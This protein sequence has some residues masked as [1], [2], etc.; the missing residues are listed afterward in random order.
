MKRLL[1][2]SLALVFCG[3]AAADHHKKG[4]HDGPPS[5]AVCVLLPTVGSQVR[6]TIMFEEKDGKVHVTG[7]VSGLTPNGKH[8]FHIHEFGDL[9]D[10][11]EGKSTGGHFS[12]GGHQHGKPSD[13]ADKRHIGDLGNLEADGSGVATI[14]MTDEVIDLHG[15]ESI[16]GRGIVV[17]KGEDKFTQPTGDAGGRAAIG[18]IG[19]AKDEMM[20]KTEMKKE[21]TGRAGGPPK[22]TAADAN[23]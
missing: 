1:T 12:P 2:L 7:K 4:E 8:G 6:G 22:P 9:S 11:Q 3:T 17:H 13:S 19:I 18:V 16:I 20:K 23:N 10:L 14:D 15:A 5:K 21:E